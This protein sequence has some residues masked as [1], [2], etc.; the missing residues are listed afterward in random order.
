MTYDPQACYCAGNCAARMARALYDRR[1]TDQALREARRSVLKAPS[2]PFTHGILG[3]LLASTGSAIYAEPHLHRSKALGQRPE[4]SDSLLG[5][6]LIGQ[7]RVK[8]AERAFLSATMSNVNH[9]PAWLGLA[10]C[11]EIAQD[12][13]RALELCNRVL[14]SGQE[15]QGLRP[16]FA[17]I[18]ARVG[19]TEEALQILTNGM[20][21]LLYDRG[22]LNEKLGRYDAA[23]A[24]YQAA[25]AGTGFKYRD[26]EAR[27]RIDAHKAFWVRSN[28]ERL[29]RLETP[30]FS[31]ITPLFICGFPRSGTTLLEAMLGSHSA[32]AQGDELRFI[33]DVAEF[34]SAW[35]S[36]TERYPESLMELTLGDKAAVLR[37]MRAYYITK[38][39]DLAPPGAKYIT[40]KMPLNE[41]HLGLMFLMFGEAPIVYIRRHPLDIIVSNFATY[42]THGFNQAFELRTA[43]IHYLR[44]DSL[45]QHYR[46]KLP[47]LNLIEVRYEE[48]VKDPAGQSARLVASIGLPSEALDHTRNQNHPR[49]PSYQ[50]VKAPVNADAIGR[51]RKFEGYL[52]EAREIV[53][54]ILQREGYD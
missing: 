29:P 16:L 2:C 39:L 26:R 35:L 33:H 42:L 7:G 5:Q 53:R 19:R 27:H 11:A 8:D 37:A 21:H 41:M 51:W 44:V 25:N 48:L 6:C 15:V 52:G 1:Q 40:D 10:Q 4:I 13:E 14:K 31:P 36:S 34:S 49:T 45:L 23:F 30:L 46:A 54:P 12:N 24:D 28:I 20:P 9:L 38:C 47:E 43:A 22:K 50:A 18:L 17:K 3:E 32:I